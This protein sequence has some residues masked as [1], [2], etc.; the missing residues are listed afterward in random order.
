[1]TTISKF[2]LTSVATLALTASA[3]TVRLL[4]TAPP[5][6]ATMITTVR[7]E[8]ATDKTTVTLIA[9]GQLT[10]ANVSELPDKPRRLVLDFANVSANASSRTLSSALV[11]KVRVAV[12]SRNPLVTRVVLEIDAHATYHV[13]RGTDAA[14]E[15]A[16]VFEPALAASTMLLPTGE[17][18]P[19]EPEP[20]ISMQQALA[21]AATL[22]PPAEAPKPVA[23]AAAPVA[24]V[25]STVVRQQTAPA[26]TPQQLPT[27]QPPT[28]P[29]PPP[30]Q[31]IGP[32]GEKQYIGAPLTLDFAGADLRSVLRA[33]IAHGGLNVVFDNAVQGNIDIVLNDIPW[34]QALETILRA[35]KLGYVAEGTIIRIA[36]VAVLAEEEAERRKLAEARALAGDLRV[37]TFALSYA[38]ATEMQPLLTK[39]ALSAR[40]QI[41]VDGRT[42]TLIIT[43]L[44]DRLQIASNLI[45]GLDRP[46]PQVEVEARIVQT[47]RDFAKAIGIQWGLNGRMS[48]EIG[49]TTGLAFPNRGALGGR[50]GPPQGAEGT[51]TRANPVDQTGTVVGLPATAI[52][53]AA[54]NTAVGLALGS[55]NGAFNLDVAL[56]ALE[57]SGKGRVLSTPRLTTQNNIAAEVGQGVQIP[58]QTV[59]NNTVTVT[60]KEA[61]LKLM[62]TPQITAAGTVIMQVTIENASADFS[63]VVNGIPPID[64]QRAQTQVQVNDGATT[65]IGGIFVSREQSST[66]RTPMIS[67]VPLLGWL[68]RR[69]AVQDESREL[70]IFITPR[71][72]KG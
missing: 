9:D 42:N 18:I 29:N 63:R 10:P 52:G 20:A 72:L 11:Q 15:L 12:N 68:F 28:R 48:P 64:T 24:P 59:A 23:A 51:D 62:V 36:P 1:V 25:K 70:L 47:S 53:S 56:T 67:R 32:G 38:K 27:V 65:V 49:N 26:P 54:V 19:V 31:P 14:R 7:A 22:T 55:V 50:L 35:N 39:S 40:G 66:D 16:V 30:Q 71:I 43:D 4:G 46:E 37:Q 57:R 21:N 2:A 58:I 13:E 60:F 6:A 5:A 45:S 34:D 3:P 61:L 41:Q 69:D 8:D 44:P 33:I 17:P